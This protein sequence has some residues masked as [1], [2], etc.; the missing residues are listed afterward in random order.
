[1]HLNCCARR[2]P[3]PSVSQSHTSGATACEL[4]QSILSGTLLR[5]RSFRISLTVSFS[6]LRLVPPNQSSASS[7]EGIRVS[8]S[9]SCLI[10]NRSFLGCIVQA[11]HYPLI[12][13]V[14]YCLSL[15]L[16]MLSFSSLLSFFLA[17]AAVRSAVEEPA[18]IV[19]ATTGKL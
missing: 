7:S 17:I 12:C 19:V 2:Q 3:A 15:P 14:E 1:M 8:I 6:L 13:L 9:S 11:D 10:T 16:K 5:C 4:E 18:P